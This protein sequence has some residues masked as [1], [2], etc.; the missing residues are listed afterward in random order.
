MNNEI[1][2]KCK[3]LIEQSADENVDLR[4]L[5]SNI[6]AQNEILSEVLKKVNS[7]EFGLEYQVDD[8]SHATAI[9]G[10]LKL[11]EVL[12]NVI[13]VQ[14]RLSGDQ[15]KLSKKQAAIQ[16]EGIEAASNQAKSSDA[17]PNTSDINTQESS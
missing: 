11:A 14:E 6:A 17:K 3:E 9:L 15:T 7:I 8:P 1:V 12:E 10:Q 2:E 5:G 4:K 13:E 16:T